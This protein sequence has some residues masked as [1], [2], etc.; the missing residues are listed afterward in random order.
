MYESVSDFHNDEPGKLL[1]ASVSY[2]SCTVYSCTCAC[3]TIR[4]NGRGRGRG[5][6][7]ERER[8]GEKLQ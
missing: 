4:E 8:E 1:F 7:R 3:N 6:G 5:R 2:I